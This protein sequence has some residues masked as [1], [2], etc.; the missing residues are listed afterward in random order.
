MTGLNRRTLLSGMG[1]LS[2]MPAGA[3]FART[4]AR[5]VVIGAGFGG[6][7]AARSLKALLP[8]ASITLI[9]P[10]EA[11]ISCPFSNLIMGGDR[12][13]SDQTFP[14]NGWEGRGIEHIRMTARSVDP[15]KRA[16][17]LEDGAVL[18]YD[19]LIL[20][21]GIVFRWGA[22]EGY[23]PE[24]TARMPHAWKAGP[25]TNDLR[26]Q[27]VDMEDGG[28]VYMSSPEAPY[29]CPPGP[30]ERASLIAH[31]LK[32]QKPKSKLII[33]DSKDTFSKKPL[34]QEA[35]AEDYPDH[36]EWVSAVDDGRVSRVDTQAMTLETDFETHKADVAN[37]IPPQK[38]ALIAER[39]G[40]TDPTGWCPINAISFES[41]LQS[42]IH[43]IGDA[44]IAA[45]MP[46][47][48]FSANL[49]GKVCA[50]QVARLLNGLAPEPTRL[51]NT[52]YSFT[53]P[54]KAISIVGA[55]TNKTGQF[56][57]IEG[58]GGIS[59]LAAPDFVRELEAVQA[60]AWFDA[61][62]SETFG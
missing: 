2:L 24:A 62:I 3:A 4:D 58:A 14:I 53:S 20:A 1:A 52:C 30:Y 54:E 44:A 29:R 56:Q 43:I 19:R 23:S 46:K 34:F 40:V 32:T 33:L 15:I 12:S 60:K 57:S 51:V 21:P 55:Y 7:T 45:P 48:A 28:T 35:W 41:S 50:I 13:L 17:E 27:L 39:S 36:L 22:I 47:S 8:R 5:L 26:R 49:Q 61:I 11:Y 6:A 25:Q 9:D 37:I 16:V 59:P 38:A 10:A 31:Y 18:A 42:H